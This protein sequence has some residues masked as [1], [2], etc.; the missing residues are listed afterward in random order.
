MRLWESHTGFYVLTVGFIFMHS[1]SSQNE[2][3]TTELELENKQ[4]A[5]SSQYSRPLLVLSP[6]ASASI[7]HP[8]CSYTYSTVFTHTTTRAYVNCA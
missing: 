4:F 3:S 6:S 1:S 2:N 7:Y 5:I 8:V